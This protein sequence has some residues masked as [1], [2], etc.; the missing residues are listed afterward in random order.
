ML[1]GLAPRRALGAPR[2]RV[3]AAALLG[4]AL[5]A[6]VAVGLRM[7]GMDAGPGSALGSMGWYL[8]IWVTMMAAMMLPSLTPM[9]LL[10][11]RVARGSARRP[12][13]S[14]AVFVAGYL[15]LWTGYGILAYGLD[16]LVRA[17]DLPFLA[18]DS[19]GPL[20][21]GAAI[22][23]AGVYQLTPLKRVC[24]RHCRSPFHAVLHGWREGML[25][26]LRMGVRHGATCVGCCVGLM[27]VLFAV[28]VMSITWMALVATIVFAEKVLPGGDRV[29]R[30]LALVLVALGLWVALAPGSVPGLTEPAPGMQM[31]GMPPAPP[32]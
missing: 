13:A 10:H 4:G 14:T 1:D 9:V 30:A 20:A 5:A 29:S 31:S 24:L 23:L 16:R 19:G 12:G 2:P 8:G 25:G 18:W 21:A 17:A 11:A 22:A 6:W 32:S 15:I 7:R 28:G 27:L 26:A 3:V